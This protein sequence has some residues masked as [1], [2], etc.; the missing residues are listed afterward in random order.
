MDKNHDEALNIAALRETLLQHKKR[1]SLNL[2]ACAGCSLCAE[3]C[4]LFELHGHDPRYMPSYKVLHSLGA[5]Y[6][7]RGRVTRAQLHDMAGLVWCNCVLCGRCYCPFG[8]DI[9]VMIALVRKILREQN[10]DGVYPH[11]LG[12]PEDEST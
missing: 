9:P 2:K 6:R 10:I 1:M 8:I 4:F 5:L 7:A 3:S 11:S 12:A